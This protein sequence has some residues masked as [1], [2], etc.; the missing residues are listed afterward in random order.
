[1]LGDFTHEPSVSRLFS[2]DADKFPASIA[3]DRKGVT[4]RCYDNFI[5]HIFMRAVTVVFYERLPPGHIRP[6]NEFAVMVCSTINV[7]IAA[8]FSILRNYLT[9]RYIL[10]L[11]NVR[12]IP[13]AKEDQ[14]R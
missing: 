6:C 11:V 14:F 7:D 10:C 9:V 2:L 13:L 1:M 4:S 8:F 12:Y 3:V 5:A